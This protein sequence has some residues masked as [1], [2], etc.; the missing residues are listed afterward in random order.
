MAY[1]YGSRHQMELFPQTVEEYV[2][3][4]DPVRVYDAF[5][6]TLS[7]NELVTCPG[8]Y[9]SIDSNLASGS[10]NGGR[11]AKTDN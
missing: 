2:K 5:I 8:G 6:E 9:Y 10:I 11:S 7:C 3:T 4:D 1:R